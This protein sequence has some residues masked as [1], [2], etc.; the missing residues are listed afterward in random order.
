M[1]E[2]AIN[3]VKRSEFGKGASRRDRRAGLVPA[4]IYG[5]GAEPRHV[6][7]PARELTAALKHANVL[8]D[9]NVD[10]QAT[11]V[12]PKSVTKHPLSQ[13]L[14][15]VDLL[16]VSRS[17][18]VVVDIPVHTVGEHDRDGILEHVHNSVHVE[19]AANAIPESLTLDISGMKA[20]TSKFAS[21]VTLPAG[22][23]ISGDAHVVIV[24]LSEKTVSGDAAAA[25]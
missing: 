18:R 6:S 10:G 4:V 7:L 2:I 12:L 23:K 14:E 15:H 17:E 16:V 1:A 22:A 21:D 19:V 24:H 3:G 20:G 13:T 5:H 25:E 11:L 9:L 8:L